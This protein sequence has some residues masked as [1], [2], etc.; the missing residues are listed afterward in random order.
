MET[1]KHIKHKVLKSRKHDTKE[2]RGVLNSL[3]D[4]QINNCKAGPHITE[5]TP[6]VT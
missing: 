5:S 4:Q 3:G 2:D 6:K 1:R